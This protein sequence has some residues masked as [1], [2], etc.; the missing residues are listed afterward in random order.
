MDVAEL[1]AAYGYNSGAMKKE[2]ATFICKSL[3]DLF[4]NSHERTLE[5]KAIEIALQKHPTLYLDYQSA[6]A[7]LSAEPSPALEELYKA[8]GKLQSVLVQE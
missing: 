5:L 8:I 4:K 7:A 1:L 6:L 2:A 3:Y